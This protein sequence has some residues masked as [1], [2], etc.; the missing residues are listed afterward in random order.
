MIAL[1]V[2]RSGFHVRYL[3]ATALAVEA[4]VIHNFIWH[5]LY[6]WSGRVCSSWRGALKRLIRFNLSNGAISVAGNLILMKAGMDLVHVHYLI[7]N[8]I[9]IAVCSLLNFLVCERC[10]FAIKPYPASNVKENESIASSPSGEIRGPER[11][12]KVEA[13]VDGF[14]A[15]ARD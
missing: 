14:V 9:A 12:R 10:V 8:G 6:T 13:K 15:V 7:A 5:Y 2:L 11:G 1:F 4:A 3:T